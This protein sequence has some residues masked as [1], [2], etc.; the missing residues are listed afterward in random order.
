[1]RAF[2]SEKI[3]LQVAGRSSDWDGEIDKGTQ[4]E[5][6]A[7]TYWNDTG[8]SDQEAKKESLCWK[9]ERAT[10]LGTVVLGRAPSSS[11]SPFIL[12]QGHFP[13]MTLL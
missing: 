5:A 13:S 4:A 1:M 6:S 2:S 9:G 11:S 12:L 10:P 3:E 8:L 7:A